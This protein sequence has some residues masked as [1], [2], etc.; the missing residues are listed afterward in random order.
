MKI[1]Y[2]KNI[3]QK[4]KFKINYWLK[5]FFY[6]I[7]MRFLAELIIKYKLACIQ[8][9]AGAGNLDP[10]SKNEGFYEVIRNVFK[11]YKPKIHIYE[12]N[13]KNQFA[14]KKSWI[15]YS[16]FVDIFQEGVSLSNNFEKLTFYFHPLDGP[17]YQVCSIQ[18]DHV[19]KHFQGSTVSDLE[20]FVCDCSP[21]DK[22]FER[23]SNE[24][25]PDIFIAIDAEGIDYDLL[26]TLLNSVYIQKCFIISFEKLHINKD[27]Y[28]DL[29]KIA[30]FKGFVLAGFGVDPLFYDELLVKKN[31]I[32]N[33]YFIMFIQIIKTIL[34]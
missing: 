19:L 23:I 1:P 29:K 22:L 17:H 2:L 4:I 26:K 21:V 8:I 15:E 6:E 30:N 12:P 33:N 9:G 25:N 32:K 24:Y 16:E 11:K 5:T 18:K 10:S 14:L 31:L 7:S 20:T 13:P 28:K 34:F 3:E 27:E